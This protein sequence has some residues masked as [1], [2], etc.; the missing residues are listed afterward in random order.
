VAL[1]AALALSTAEDRRAAALRELEETAIILQLAVERELGLTIAAL[2]ALAT[3]PALDDALAS[4]PGGPGTAA[5]HAQASEVVAR[6]PAA[7]G[8]IWL[9][10]AGGNRPVVSTTGPPRDMP[11]TVSGTRFPPRPIGE[12]PEPGTSLREAERLGRPYVGDLVHGIVSGWMVPVAMPVRRNGE[13]VAV[14]AAA[15]SP[16]SLGQIMREHLPSPE[17]IAAVADRGGVLVARTE[18]AE[19]FIGGPA[20]TEMVAFQ[21]D[22]ALDTATVKGFGLNGTPLYAA[23][24]RLSLA[25]LAVGYGAPQTLVDAPV[26]RAMLATGAGALLAL[27]VAVGAAWLFGRQLGA[28][29]AALGA[30]ALLLARGTAPPPR[31]PAEVEEVATAR[32]ALMRSAASLAESETRFNRAVVAARMGTWEWDFSTNTLNGSPGREALYARAPG[33]LATIDALMSAVHPEDRREITDAMRKAISDVEN[34]RYEAEFRTVWPDGTVRWLRTQGRA[35]FDAGGRPL[36]MSGVVVDVTDRR[37]AETALRESEGRFRLAQE[38]AGIGVWERDLRSGAV[39]WS[40]Q[41][42]KVFGLDP[43]E[44]PPGLDALRA[45]IVPED[46]KLAPLFPSLEGVALGT[47]PGPVRSAV[48]RI[49]R[50]DDGALRWVQVVG[51]ALPGPDGRAARVIGVT[52]DVTDSRQAEERQ[53]LLMREV[54]HRAKNALAVAL[55]VVQLAPRDLSPDAFAAAVTGR[56]AAMARA[57]SLLAAERWSGAELRTL[58]AAELALHE[59]RVRLSGPRL[60]LTADAA[61]PVAMLLHELATNAAKHGALSTPEG[62]VELSWRTACDE[63]ELRWRESGGPP[64]AGPPSRRG[65][66]SRLLNSLAQRQLSG[67]IVFDWSDGAGLQVVVHLPARHVAMQPAVAAL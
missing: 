53:S 31:P 62:R 33:S 63:L 30:D 60:R 21:G 41:E 29:V 36:R 61:Q 16:S 12:P 4:T 37:I 45:M 3:S 50:A 47:D 2:E 20:A 18:D 24:R 9:L 48:Y 32:A 43:A 34:G 65:F 51:R 7:I 40:E 17:G 58:A 49:R 54:D 42:Y 11:P 27:A 23:I 39:T 14:L 64:L 10:P 56:I 38:A 46:R 5:F 35:E 55:S 6:R 8:S 28:E 44:A 26:H 19:R 25:R 13:I 67:R 66:G 57:H 59:G 1:A 52:L 22:P 15:V